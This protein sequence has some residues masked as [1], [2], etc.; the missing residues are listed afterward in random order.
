MT[1][2]H[3]DTDTT[4]WTRDYW[5]GHCEGFRVDGPQGRVGF[6]ETVLGPEGE[7]EALLVRG[8][9]LGGRVLVVPIEAV[10]DVRPRAERIVIRDEDPVAP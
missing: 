7:P 1:Q 6:V 9:I 4:Y 5:L 2:I 8:G 10:E 3:A